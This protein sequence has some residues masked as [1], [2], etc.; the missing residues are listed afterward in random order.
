MTPVR[1]IAHKHLSCL[2]RLIFLA[3]SH[4]DLQLY[5][6]MAYE[7]VSD[8]EITDSVEA[9][10]MERAGKVYSQAMQKRHRIAHEAF[11]DY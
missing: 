7:Y 8:R 9:K 1:R 10:V 4:D 5:A 6:S 2:E 3:E 11:S